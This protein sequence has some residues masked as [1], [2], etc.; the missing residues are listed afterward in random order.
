M[1]ATVK[2]PTP[3]RRMTGGAD[4]LET[5]RGTLREALDQL[6]KQFPGLKARLL[7]DQTGDIHPFISIFINGDDVRYMRGLDS[8][9]KDG[10]EVTIVPAIAGGSR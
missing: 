10:D 1:P 5:P 3:L 2:V 6:D 8:A 4:L 9:L 7:D